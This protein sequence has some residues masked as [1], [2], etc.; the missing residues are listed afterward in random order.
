MN[1]LF[2]MRIIYDK[3]VHNEHLS[4]NVRLTTLNGRIITYQKQQTRSAKYLSWKLFSL[5][6]T[7]K[8][9]FKTKLE[10]T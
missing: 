10:F 2:K 5:Q 3:T 4:I 6:T 1:F 9:L 7:A 8:Q